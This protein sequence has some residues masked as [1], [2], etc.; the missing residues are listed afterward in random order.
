MLNLESIDVQ[1]QSRI[2]GFVNKNIDTST[3]YPRGYGYQKDCKSN[4][5]RGFM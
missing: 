2:N 1:M 5:L 3:G 4:G